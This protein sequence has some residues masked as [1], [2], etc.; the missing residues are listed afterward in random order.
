MMLGVVGLRL[1]HRDRP[2]EERAGKKRKGS[3]GFYF[4]LQPDAKE[5]T[6]HVESLDPR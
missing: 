4:D 6:G 3:V 2:D 5:R 1:P